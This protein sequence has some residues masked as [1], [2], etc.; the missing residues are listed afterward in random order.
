MFGSIDCLAQAAGLREESDRDNRDD[1]NPDHQMHPFYFRTSRGIGTDVF[2]SRFFGQMLRYHGAMG[3]QPL[4]EE[5]QW[6][7]SCRRREPFRYGSNIE[8]GDRGI[9]VGRIEEY[10]MGGEAKAL[11]PN[12]FVVIHGT[13]HVERD[14]NIS[15]MKQLFDCMEEA[16]SLGQDPGWPHITVLSTLP[17]HFN[18]ESGEYTGEGADP[19]KYDGCRVSIDP[20]KYPPL[21][22]EREH[23]FG[24][25][26]MV[27]HDL[28]LEH[29][30]NYH[31][32]KRLDHVKAIDCTHWSM[33]G[34]PDLVAK[35]V[36][37][38]IQGVVMSESQY[39]LGTVNGPPAVTL[40]SQA[41]AETFETACKH[42]G[43]PQ[44]M[45]KIPLSPRAYGMDRGRTANYRVGIL[46]K[47]NQLALARS[48]PKVPTR[49]IACQL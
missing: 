41:G 9:F 47:V 21:M 18:T 5:L 34:V 23:F 40:S 15:N 22:E 4:S 31:V 12:D 17:Q 14:E 7:E 3:A 48:H 8:T 2:Y 46:D 28:N 10:S 45:G 24:K 37:D 20:E 36:L 29:M 25:V 43:L 30:G 27:G 39:I 33:P 44:E 32:G 35:S 49:L 42:L 19:G 26:P 1:P 16:R 13:L 11:S 38:P 6:I